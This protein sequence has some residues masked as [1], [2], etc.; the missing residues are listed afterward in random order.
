MYWGTFLDF[1]TPQDLLKVTMETQTLVVPTKPARP[2][3]QA[4]DLGA[5]QV[6]QERIVSH[7][8][9]FLSVKKTTPTLPFLTTQSA[10]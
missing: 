6:L 5:S 4:L 1:S 2:L 8:V 9:T 7:W 3:V 10:G